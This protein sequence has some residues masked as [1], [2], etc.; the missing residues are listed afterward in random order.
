M[1][2]LVL[3]A[4]LGAI[5][6]LVRYGI[7]TGVARGVAGGFPWGTLA[8]N[9]SGCFLFGLVATLARERGVIQP[10]TASI[11]L[12][13]FMGAYTTF[14]SFVG[15]TV[16]LGTASGLGLALV[17]VLVENTGGIACFLAGSALA[18]LV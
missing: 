3:L 5:G 18:R 2:K 11:V 13:G 8:V 14:S 1:H 12:V 10:E 17:N 6:T 7:A 16:A 15:D 4:V 9:L